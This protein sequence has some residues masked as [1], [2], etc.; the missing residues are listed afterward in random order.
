MARYTVKIN[1]KDICT[2]ESNTLQ[3]AKNKVTRLKI[4]TV[5]DLVLM[6][7]LHHTAAIRRNGKWFKPSR[8][9]R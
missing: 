1:E 9:T 4:V 2:V 8:F 5:H 6:Q 7:G 3:G